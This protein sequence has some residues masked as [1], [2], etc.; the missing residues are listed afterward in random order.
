MGSFTFSCNRVSSFP[1]TLEVALLWANGFR[2]NTSDNVY[3]KSNL[4]ICNFL[5]IFS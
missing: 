5:P 1:F 4:L 3:T 2:E